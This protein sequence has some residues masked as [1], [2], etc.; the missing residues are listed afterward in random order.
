MERGRGGRAG[1]GRPSTQQQVKRG[2][3]AG[4][5]TVLLLERYIAWGNGRGGGET[6]RERVKVW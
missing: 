1:R 2:W 6:V 3:F 5:L 4:R